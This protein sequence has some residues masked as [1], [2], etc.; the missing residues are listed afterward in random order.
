MFEQNKASRAMALLHQRSNLLL[1]AD[2]IAT[3]NPDYCFSCK[4]NYLDFILVVGASRGLAIFIPHVLV[5]HTFSIELNLRLQIRQFRAK[6][7]TVGFN[8]T[9]AMWCVGKTRSEELWIGMAPNEYFD[10]DTRTFVNAKDCGDTRLTMRHVRIM[11]A[12]IVSLLAQLHGRQFEFEDPY[13]TDLT[14]V[15]QVRS[16][17]M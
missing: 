11:Q 13:A 15:W 17:V 10:D 3:N 2:L 14:G 1:D 5:D 16:N 9:G 7:G 4:K 6:H 8:P 12:F